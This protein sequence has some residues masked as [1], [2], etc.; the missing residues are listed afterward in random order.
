[1]GDVI[2]FGHYKKNKRKGANQYIPP[3]INLIEVHLRDFL[4]KNFNLN[5]V[6]IHFDRFEG[7]IIMSAQLQTKRSR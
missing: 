4:E 6:K 1:M 7:S 5:I 2:D 3:H